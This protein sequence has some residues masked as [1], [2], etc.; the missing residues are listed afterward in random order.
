[1]FCFFFFFYYVSWASWWTASREETGSPS[2]PVQPCTSKRG[3]KKKK[4]NERKECNGLTV[5]VKGSGEFMGQLISNLTLCYIS[6]GEFKK[7]A[8]QN[9]LVSKCKCMFGNDVLFLC[10]LWKVSIKPL[11][12][13]G[14]YIYVNCSSSA[15]NNLTNSCLAMWIHMGLHQHI[16]TYSQ[17]YFRMGNI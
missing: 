9:C 10:C 6:V 17:M 8:K 7:K 2:F 15:L 1:M 3:K 16:Y 5:Q 11:T 12:A 4:T 13:E 14:R